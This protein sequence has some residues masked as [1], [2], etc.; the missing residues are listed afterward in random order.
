MRFGFQPQRTWGFGNNGTTSPV[1]PSL[2]AIAARGADV[3]VVAKLELCALGRQSDG[4]SFRRWGVSASSCAFSS[5]AWTPSH[6][7]ASSGRGGWAGSLNLNRMLQR[8]RQGMAK[9]SRSA[10]TRG[11]NPSL[12]RDAGRFCG[13]RS[14]V[15]LRRNEAYHPGRDARRVG[16][17]GPERGMAGRPLSVIG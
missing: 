1:K 17:H 6:P 16:A 10:N 14:R 13:M 7:A 11:E 4:H 3:F 9:R 5:W 8:Q 2:S 15:P 12:P